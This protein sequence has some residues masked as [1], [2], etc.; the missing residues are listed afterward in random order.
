M[1]CVEGRRCC[2]DLTLL[3]L[4]C[5]P[6]ATALIQPL[7]WEPPYAAGVGLKTKRKKKI[8]WWVPR[9]LLSSLVLVFHDFQIQRQKHR[10][11]K[12]LRCLVGSYFSQD[13]TP[14]DVF[15]ES[16]WRSLHICLSGN[17]FI[18]F[19]VHINKTRSMDSLW[20]SCS[21]LLSS[22]SQ[23]CCYFSQ[24]IRGAIPLTVPATW[25][26]RDGHTSLFEPTI[27]DSALE[28]EVMIINSLKG[29]AWLS[30]LSEH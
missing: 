27:M 17:A 20:R 10:R 19:H 15:F 18:N 22:K 24:V 28:G 3:W 12:S 2:S 7:A 13:E 21:R 9:L 26:Q 16:Q 25:V 11:C 4:W 23:I 30:T 14:K 6:V 8:F 1:S 5:R 29:C